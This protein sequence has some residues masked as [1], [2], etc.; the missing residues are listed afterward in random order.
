MENNWHYAPSNHVPSLEPRK[1]KPQAVMRAW[2]LYISEAPHSCV[3]LLVVTVHIPS[4]SVLLICF[5]Y[6]Q[7]CV[8]LSF[9]LE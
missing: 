1:G 9:I 2:S 5:E 4:Y 7:I 6:F 3:S 8:H